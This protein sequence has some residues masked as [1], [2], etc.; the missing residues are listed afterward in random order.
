[1]SEP[2][3]DLKPAIRSAK[4]EITE[5][6][7]FV[8]WLHGQHQ[9]EFPDCR[10]AQI[11]DYLSSGQS[12]RHQIRTF[13]VWHLKAGTVAKLSVPHC[14]DENKP[15]ITQSRRIE[16]IGHCMGL[17][18]TAKSSRVAGLILLL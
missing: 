16:L 13:I 14:Y 12:T 1:M 8:T 10:Q 9:I 5:A 2:G 15:L 3:R 7:K 6:G 17:S 11:E 18:N 4:Q